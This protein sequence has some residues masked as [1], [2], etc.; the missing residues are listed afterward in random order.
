MR[1]QPHGKTNNARREYRIMHRNA[2]YAKDKKK[3]NTKL[4]FFDDVSTQRETA[5]AVIVI[6]DGLFVS[7]MILCGCNDQ[8]AVLVI[9]LSSL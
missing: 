8:A 5:A 1:M 7:S 4:W 3:F 2:M 6:V 9:T